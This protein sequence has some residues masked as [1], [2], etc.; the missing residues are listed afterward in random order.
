MK[1]LLIED[2]HTIAL[3]IVEFLSSHQWQV[4]H[5]SNAELGSQ[6]ALAEI[7]DVIL[8]DLNL[9]DKDGLEV[10]QIIKDNAQI[11]PPILMLTARDSFED[12]S[13]GF[14]Q[15][16]DD[17]LTKPF[18]LR[19]LVLRCQAL[20]RRHNLHQSKTIT[21]KQLTLDLSN[22]SASIEGKN[23]ALTSIGFKILALLVKAYPEP[24]SRSFITHKLWSDSPPDSDALKSHIYTL[25][26]A[27]DTPLSNVTVKTVMNVGYKLEC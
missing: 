14:K 8:L 7:Y 15:G 21:L 11:T 25:R 13:A 10:C 3:Q 24:V 19:E 4:D 17:Y 20:T 5:A 18:D 1:I 16:A 9:P 22:N 6:L 2:N 12:K 23:L 27:L 26:K